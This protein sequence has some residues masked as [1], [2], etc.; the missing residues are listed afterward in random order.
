MQ[1]VANCFLGLSASHIWK[2]LWR[3]F[4][5]TW[6]CENLSPFKNISGKGNLHIYKP[7]CNICSITCE[8]QFERWCACDIGNACDCWQRTHVVWP[9]WRFLNW[10]HIQIS[11]GHQ[12]GLTS[13]LSLL[14]PTILVMSNRIS[15]TSGTLNPTVFPAAASKCSGCYLRTHRQVHGR[16]WIR[17]VSRVSIAILAVPQ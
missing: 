8:L 12:L 11:F 7:T 3:V 4:A 13:F 5:C 2:F 16:R 17:W 1:C 6:F 15:R 10:K 9:S 14:L